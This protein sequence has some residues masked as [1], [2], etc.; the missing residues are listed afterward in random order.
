M[1]EVF[2]DFIGKFYTNDRIV[3]LGKLAAEHGWAFAKRARFA[4]QTTEIKHFKLFKG[5]RGKRVTGLCEIG[6]ADTGSATRVYDYIYYSDGGKKK[7]TVIEVFVPDLF[8]TQF[9]IFP[10][11]ALK[12]LFQRS[13][14]GDPALDLFDKHYQIETADPAATDQEVPDS[15]LAM[16]A[17]EKGCTLEGAGQYLVF[18]KKHKQL[19]VSEILPAVDLVLNIADAVQ[20]DHEKD[21]V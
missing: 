17:P 21:F 13:R 14:N 18:Y 8:L 1:E 5:K 9:R 3:A 7:T 11:P 16:I 12:S 4:E 10:K 20:H 15:V 6:L 19:P 2:D